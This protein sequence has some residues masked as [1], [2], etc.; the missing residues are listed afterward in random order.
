M[1]NQYVI[2]RHNRI[3]IRTGE[4]SHSL[5]RILFL[6][7]ILGLPFC[8]SMLGQSQARCRV[9]LPMQASSG[10]DIT[11]AIQQAIDQCSSGGGGTVKIPAGHYLIRPI[12]LKNRVNLYLDAGSVLRG[13]ADEAA[14][15]V[16]MQNIWQGKPQDRPLALIG[17]VGQKHVS[18]TGPGTIDGAGAQWWKRYD[19]LR[20]KT[21]EEMARP[22]LVQFT[23]CTHVVVDGVELRDSPSYTL[24]PFLSN[25]VTIRNVRIVAPQ[26]SPNTDG[27]VPYS[28][29]HVRVTGSTVDSGD[30]NV[31]IKS[32]RPVGSGGDDF[33]AFDITISDC[34]FLHGHGATIGAD[35]G[36]GVHDVV[37][38]NIAFRGTTNGLRIKSGREI[39][40]DVSHIT[41]RHLTMTD[42][43][44]AVSILEYYPRTPEE[45]TTQPV[46]DSTPRFHDIHIID[47]SAS[48]GKDAGS[49]VGLPE[50]PVK[51]VFFENVK[52]SAGAGLK[53]RNASVS[54]DRGTEIKAAGGEDVIRQTGAEII[55]PQ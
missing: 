2:E 12:A 34:T 14:Y 39:S 9:G 41:Y 18:L 55:H 6:L 23:R 13:V 16:T 8:S 24:V 28:S 29:H 45:D 15:P 37:M 49:I 53:V 1:R 44:P 27:I 47:L 25:D 4:R 21:G 7:V 32:S 31:A 33:S 52:I 3:T 46:N 22:W 11:A 38:E 54:L 5:H 26:D 30:D 51:N 19:E 35:T 40:G 10:A 17:A 42:T 50:S 36:G 48:G 43:S 20:K